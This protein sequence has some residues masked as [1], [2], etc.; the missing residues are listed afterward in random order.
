MLLL[1]DIYVKGIAALSIGILGSKQENPIPYLDM[2]KALLVDEARFVKWNASVGMA[3]ILSVIQSKARRDIFLKDLLS[4]AYWYFRVPGAIGLGFFCDVANPAN[5]SIV[6]NQFKPMLNDSDIDVRV[7]AVYGLGF[8]AKKLNGTV[9]LTQFFK[10][11]LY[12]YDPAVV[13]GAKVVLN[14][15]KF[16]CKTQSNL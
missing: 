6:I 2:L 10:I 16:P 7:G 1:D 8:I 5:L 12:D 13:L 3:F 15:L 4:S 9:D 11:C 14:F